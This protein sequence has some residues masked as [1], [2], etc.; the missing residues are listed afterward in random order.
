MNSAR[1]SIIVLFEKDK[2]QVDGDI[3]ENTKKG[4]ETSIK[5]GERLASVL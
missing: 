5:M 3:L 2:V 4:Y 1:S